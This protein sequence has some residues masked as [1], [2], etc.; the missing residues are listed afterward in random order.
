[1]AK[2]R[3][4]PFSEMSSIFKS[5]P[6]KKWEIYFHFFSQSSP[7]KPKFVKPDTT[8]QSSR[9]IFSRAMIILEDEEVGENNLEKYFRYIPQSSLLEGPAGSVNEKERLNHVPWKDWKRE[10]SRE[11]RGTSEKEGRK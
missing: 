7:H 10:H 5:P 3:H 6:R 8:S 11:K 1:M 2:E 4:G 9:V